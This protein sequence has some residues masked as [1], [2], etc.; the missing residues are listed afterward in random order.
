MK[1][2]KRIF[3]PKSIKYLN[4]L[5]LEKER[6][7]IQPKKESLK[8]KLEHVNNQ[9]K[10]LYLKRKQSG[11]GSLNK[12]VRL[13][14]KRQSLKNKLLRLQLKEAKIENKQLEKL[15]IFGKIKQWFSYIPYKKQSVIWGVVFLVP[16][17]IGLFVFF[18]P[19]LLR[20]IWWS[21]HEVSPDSTTL[22]VVFN[23][24]DNY[25]FLFNEYVIDGNNIFKVA[26][27]Q[28][29]QDLIIDLPIIIIFSLF[30][31]VL[32]NKDFKGSRF[33]KAV[34]FIPVIYNLTVISSTI[35]GGF[36]GYLD[37]S[38]SSNLDPMA[39]MTEF[40]RDI[41][42]ANNLVTTIINA[43]NRIF[44]IVNY[45]GIQIL[46]F[47]TALQSIPK[48]LY[49]AA[50]VEGATKYEE[51]WKITIPM[52][53]PMILTASIYTVIDSFARAPIFRFLTYA[54]VQSKYGLAS[55]ISVSYLAINLVV[56]FI[57]FL[58][59]KGVVFYYDD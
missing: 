44:T 6:Q 21:F 28:F 27:L 46:I 7:K 52:V 55:A 9:Y 38:V 24:L 40:L 58:G 34:F 12:I 2:L 13:D 39:K 20:S 53:T 43:V 8:L 32:L 47:I 11:K 22:H 50:K 49:E 1:F 36:G 5:E 4:D 18:I 42:I 14:D 31:A 19:P 26:I 57:I 37:S 41:G 15:S 25:K 16:L 33:I 23:G 3:K 54:T 30:I 56:V 17:G 48:H 51:F 45:S 29:I 59:M 35:S 10:T